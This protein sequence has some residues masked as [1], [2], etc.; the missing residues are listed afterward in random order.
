MATLEPA[1][2]F[3]Q[4][5]RLIAT[6]SAGAP[7]QVDLRR[8]ISAA[9]YGVFHAIVTAASDFVVGASQRQTP[10]YGLVYR[11]IEHRALRTLC[12]D[13]GKLSMPAKYVPYLPASGWGA[14]IAA[15]AAAVPDL[16]K[17][18][19]EADYDP[20]LRFYSSD[21]RL[22]VSKARTAVMRLSA[23]DSESRRIFLTLLLFPPRSP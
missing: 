16:Q 21:A 4:A 11:S 14:D 6:A 12:E 17:K 7:R 19:H 20:T 2:L 13:I 18:R 5:D 8:A 22:E 9:Y 15:L 3:E 23:A 1:H 10:W